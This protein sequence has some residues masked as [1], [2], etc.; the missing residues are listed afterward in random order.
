ML[1]CYEDKDVFDVVRLLLLGGYKET[2]KMAADANYSGCPFVGNQAALC[3]MSLSSVTASDGRCQHGFKRYD[4]NSYAPVQASNKKPRNASDENISVVDIEPL[5]QF[6]TFQT[7]CNRAADRGYLVIGTEVPH[8]K[9]LKSGAVVSQHYYVL[10]RPFYVDARQK[11]LGDALRCLDQ[12]GTTVP[13]SQLEALE[14]LPTYI[15]KVVAEGSGSLSKKFSE[16]ESSQTADVTG[17]RNW[18]AFGQQSNPEWFLAYCGIVLELAKIK[19]VTINNV[20]ID[21]NNCILGAIPLL[22]KGIFTYVTQTFGHQRANNIVPVEASINVN[23]FF[24]ESPDI[25]M[26]AVQWKNMV[27]V[28]WHLL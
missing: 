18:K 19:Q 11:L 6:E 14:Y 28:H 22:P 3:K 26:N 8:N 23:T 21:P 1:E 9:M 15:L 25:P 10:R 7:F 24:Y 17:Q 20:P 12:L 2:A 4:P 27:K 16:L 5:T 13:R